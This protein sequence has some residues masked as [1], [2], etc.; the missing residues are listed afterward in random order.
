MTGD[1]VTVRRGRPDDLPRILTLE[2]LCF[3][4][5]WPIG[6]LIPELIADDRRRPLALEVAGVVE[7][8]L[9]AW[10]VA[11]EYHIV[12]LGV[13]PGGRRRGFGT[14]LLE[15]GLAEAVGSGCT[16]ATLEVRVSNAPARSFY[17]RHGFRERGRRPH[18]Y[19]DNG[20][21]ALILTL[22]LEAEGHL[23]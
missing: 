10:I 7:G 3:E 9:M 1:G 17:W 15:A 21:D 16:S 13:A 11:D 8:Y 18:Y 14:L 22:D 2:Q 4:D 23:S 20:E 12:N 5:P 6:A 19:A